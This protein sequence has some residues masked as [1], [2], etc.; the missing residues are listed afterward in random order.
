MELLWRYKG[1][2]PRAGLL[3]SSTDRGSGP[4]LLERVAQTDLLL[5]QNTPAI[6]CST[7]LGYASG[8]RYDGSV[9]RDVES[10]S[11]W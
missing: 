5:F 10:E 7:S 11:A 3:A 8:S 6:L 9:Y 1:K 4:K 2:V